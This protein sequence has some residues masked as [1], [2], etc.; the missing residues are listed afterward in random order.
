[1]GNP[2]LTIYG[3]GRYL[4]PRASGMI[5]FGGGNTNG[6][7]FNDVYTLNLVS[8]EWTKV[9]LQGRLG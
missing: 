6:T 8:L 1:M 7:I 9:S 4:N 2:F 3:P 5:V